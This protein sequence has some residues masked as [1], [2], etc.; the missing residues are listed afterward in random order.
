MFITDYQPEEYKIAFD[1]QDGIH[2]LTIGGAR[3]CNSKSGNQMIEVAIR[4]DN[5]PQWYIERYVAGEYFNKNITR[6]FDAFKIGRGDF[7]FMNWKNKTAKG[8]FEHE[9]SE[10]TGSDGLLR[11]SNKAVL[12]RFVSDE[13]V[14]AA[15]MQ[16]ASQPRNP[17]SFQSMGMTQAANLA[18]PNQQVPTDP[19]LTTFPED[20]PF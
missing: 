17:Q 4:V 18:Q 20:I 11:T 10:Y 15:P 1:C 7:N 3:I 5:I 14:A 9:A 12:K 19:N 8:L 6:F 16:A 2:S 13:D